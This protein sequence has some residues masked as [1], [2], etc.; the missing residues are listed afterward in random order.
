MG[1]ERQG[2]AQLPG[3]LIPR[4]ECT[5][6]AKQS[7]AKRRSSSSGSFVS[8]SITICMTSRPKPDIL[9]LPGQGMTIWDATPTSR[10]RR[11]SPDAY[12]EKQKTLEEL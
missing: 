8:F 6:A 3:L 11:L 2:Q 9:V 1:I 7:I 5:V 4:Q 10:T 12:G